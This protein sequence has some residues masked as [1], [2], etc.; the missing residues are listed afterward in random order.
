MCS[1]V[2]YRVGFYGDSNQEVTTGHLD[3]A[4]ITTYA[5]TNGSTI[6]GSGSVDF[7]VDCTRDLANN[8]TCVVKGGDAVVIPLLDY[9]ID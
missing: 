2:A 6:R 7:E 1:G 4:P 3:F 5:C 9:T 8:A